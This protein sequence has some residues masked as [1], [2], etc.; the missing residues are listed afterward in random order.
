MSLGRTTVLVSALA[1]LAICLPIYSAPANTS[2]WVGSN[3]T[4]AYCV[5]AVQ[6][7][8]DFRPEV[9]EKELKAAQKYYGINTLRVYLHNLVFD[10]EKAQM[11]KRIDQFLA[12]CQ[13]HG[14]KPGFTF[15]DDC[16]NHSGIE[17]GPQ[18]P[19]VDGRHN[20]RWAACPQDS[21]RKD[22]NLPRLKAYVQEII[23]AHRADTRVLWWE[24]FNEPNSSP[25]SANL[26][27]LGYQWAKEVK[28]TQ[29]VL[30]CWDNSPETDIV[31]AHNYSADWAGWDRQ[32]DMDPAK[33]AVFTEAG[34]RWFAPRA[35]NG[36]PTEVIHWL[37]DRK[38]AGKYVPGVYL[39]W[40]LMVGNSNCRWYWG[41]PDGAPEPTVPWCGL[42]WP[43]CTPVSYAEA[44]AIHSYTTGKS[45]ALF[46]DDFQGSAAPALK[47]DGWTAYGS[48]G[49][50]PGYLELPATTKMIA[51]KSDWSDYVIEAAVMLKGTSGNAGLVFHVNDPG[52][53]QDE[54][55]GYYVGFDSNTL[56]L[57]KMNNNWR[58]LARFDITKLPCKVEPNVW[59][60]L[61]VS[62]RGN[63][64]R[65]WFNPLHDDPGL[66]IDYTDK[67]APVP[68][69]AFGVRTSGVTAWFDDVV[70]L[71]ADA[72]Q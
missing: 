30:C 36:S 62:V 52:P 15:F 60:R 23:K 65:V 17:F 29:P 50:V 21:E 11:L 27:K 63:R 71:P 31:D 1:L 47:R 2:T 68:K 51:G 66:R 34:A 13:K 7:W 25:F 48:S 18:Q 40:E 8:H 46:Y 3:Y 70:A 37:R 61:R 41:T 33:G 72:I 45:R 35:S 4:P 32:A 54:M 44:E 57:G 20:G 67:A 53:G 26:R 55:K 16:W 42:M 12:I 14:I 49:S 28:P 5:N 69:G 24:V 10:G 19:P 56:H 39:C 22:E 64:I 38:A 58:E 6:M 59:N 9:I 43:D